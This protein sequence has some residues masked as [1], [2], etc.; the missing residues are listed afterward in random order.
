MPSQRKIVRV[1]IPPLFHTKNERVEVT[2]PFIG[3]KRADISLL[4]G[5]DMTALLVHGRN[6]Y[7]HALQEA[8]KFESHYEFGGD[9]L[10]TEDARKAIERLSFPLV[11]VETF[12]VLI[13]AVDRARGSAT[14][15]LLKGIEE[16][17]LFCRTYSVGELIE[18][19]SQNNSLSLS[20]RVG[21]GR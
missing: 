20:Q 9:T 3:V 17:D 10:T 11:G 21:E 7:D 14:D 13:G 5:C 16:H 8:T 4:C 18:R 15:A 19:S 1:T 2:R 6:A 12:A